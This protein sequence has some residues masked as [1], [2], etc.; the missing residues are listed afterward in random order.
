MTFKELVQGDVEKVFLNPSEFGE[1]HVVD[2]KKMPVII[3]SHELMERKKRIQSHMDG[4]YTKQM[5]MYVAASDFGNLPA[6]GSKLLL[7]DKMYTVADAA[8]QAGVYSITIEANK[9][10]GR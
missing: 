8:S 10:R 2:G 9:G 1:E 7:D 6:Q 3:D 5:L 4:A